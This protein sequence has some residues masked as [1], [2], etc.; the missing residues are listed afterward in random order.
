VRRAILLLILALAGCS[1]DCEWW[2]DRCQEEDRQGPPGP[3]S[4]QGRLDA[5]ECLR[6]HLAGLPLLWDALAAPGRVT[7]DWPGGETIEI[8]IDPSLTFSN[9]PDRD[10]FLFRGDAA[11]EPDGSFRDGRLEIEGLDCALI[12]NEWELSPAWAGRIAVHGAGVVGTVQLAG[13]GTLVFTGSYREQ[14]TT[15][16][17]IQFMLPLN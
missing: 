16:V 5:Q 12:L 13:N 11:L 15:S 2:D 6:R 3:P 9:D 7:L 4:V 10:G 8:V 17:P 14:D 1:D